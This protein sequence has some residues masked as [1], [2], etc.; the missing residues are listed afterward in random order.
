MPAA[1]EG[2]SIPPFGLADVV[3]GP[4]LAADKIGKKI[5][6][7]DVEECPVAVTEDRVEGRQRSRDLHFEV[8]FFAHFSYS[9]LGESFAWLELAAGAYPFSLPEATA[10]DLV[11][12]EKDSPFIVADDRADGQHGY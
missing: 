10:L 9:A 3:I 4:K 8:R 6:I 11:L 12:D 7:Y 5:Y 1:G 2:I